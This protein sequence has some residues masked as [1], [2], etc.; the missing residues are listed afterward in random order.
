MTLSKKLFFSL[1][2][3]GGII[4]AQTA[5]QN[6]NDFAEF[7]P[8]LLEKKYFTRF[9]V[10]GDFA[11]VNNDNSAFATGLF[12]KYFT[13]SL[14]LSPF[15]NVGVDLFPLSFTYGAG[16]KL[17]VIDFFVTIGYLG[18]LI[19]DLE[20]DDNQFL[21]EN[22]ENNNTHLGYL[23][24][25]YSFLFVKFRNYSAYGLGL[26]IDILNETNGKYENIIDEQ[27]VN[28]T[29]LDFL[30]FSDFYTSVNLKNSLNYKYF[31][32]EKIYTL[33]YTFAIE[34]IFSF[35][36]FMEIGIVPK[37][38][39]SRS[40]D[41]EKIKNKSSFF[42]VS[43][44]PYRFLQGVSFYNTALNGEFVV[45]L[46]FGYRIFPF[47]YISGASFL[48]AFYF[49]PSI[50][51]GWVIKEGEDIGKSQIGYSPVLNIGYRFPYNS[52]KLAFGVGWNNYENLLLSFSTSI[53]Y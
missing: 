22:E 45:A 15:V 4:L 17:Q 11:D 40:S 25:G 5:N 47:T 35:E 38:I 20:I 19:L 51:S 21:L 49:Q 13:P 9:E 50:Y 37:F 2:F 3:S 26:V 12:L 32:K 24:L 36:N 53:Y 48:K 42:K 1:I 28:N 34:N 52:G 46:D 31:T 23:Y 30:I 27:F 29:S 33:D 44:A 18:K 8:D 6:D 16:V 14:V 43:P 10:V 39:V 41:S 7:T